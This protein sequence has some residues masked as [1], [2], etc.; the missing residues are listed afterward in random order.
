[1]L[2]LDQTIWCNPKW[3]HSR[4]WKSYFIFALAN[5]PLASGI[6]LLEFVSL[7]IALLSNNSFLGLQ[8]ASQ[9]WVPLW[10]VLFTSLHVREPRFQ[11]QG[12]FCLWNPEYWALESGTHL[13]DSGIPLTIGIQNPS[14]SDKEWNSVPWIWNLRHR[15]KNSRL[16]WFPLHEDPYW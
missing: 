12:N 8:I 5:H 15:I 7:K 3:D 2:F 14:S 6:K 11:N 9:V 13:K 4:W 10:P 1:M 16:Y